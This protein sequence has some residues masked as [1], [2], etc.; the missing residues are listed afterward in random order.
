MKLKKI[1]EDI[2]REYLDESYKL[3]FN[4][5]K[6][7]ENIIR[8]NYDKYKKDIKETNTETELAKKHIEHFE[9]MVNKG[10]LSKDEFDAIMQ[11]HLGHNYKRN[12]IKPVLFNQYYDENFEYVKQDYIKYKEKNSYSNF[13][14]KSTKEK[15]LE[16]SEYINFYNT[17]TNTEKQN[18]KTFLNIVSERI[19]SGTG[20]SIDRIEVR[21]S[22][23]KTPIKFQKMFSEKPSPY[24]W[25]GDY[26]HPC[27]DDYDHNDV[28]YLAMQSFTTNKNTAKE[29][30]YHFNANN[31][32]KYSGSFSVPL[33][34]KY[35]G[36]I[37]DL[38]DDEGE[39]M[40]FDV[41][42]KCKK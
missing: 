30:G 9:K 10:E 18:I 26:T 6:E 39:I 24:L 3:T 16:N 36:D 40:F 8:N 27:N 29:F 32:E 11:S 21:D 12:L 22:F 31:I 33:Y 17:L 20:E 25:R 15:K 1:A 41:S 38:S 34:I 14:H 4:D 42:Y 23:F 28:N 35:G 19:N 2:L 5:K 7:I 37:Y 13:V